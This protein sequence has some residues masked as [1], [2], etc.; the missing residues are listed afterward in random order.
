MSFMFPSP[1]M[2]FEAAVRD[3]AQGKVKARALAAQALGD[4]TDPTEKRRAVQA[5][6]V[7]LDD[8]EPEVRMEA[9]SSLGELRDPSAITLLVKRLDDGAPAVRQHAAIALGSIGGGDAC[10]PLAQALKSGPP[11]LRFQAAT[12]IAEIDGAR[13]FEPLVAALA[14]KDPQVVAAAA[15]SLGAIEDKTAIDPLAKALDHKEAATRFDIAY[16]LAEL[17]DARGREYLV[18]GLSQEDRAWDAVT[19]I[20]WLGGA[21]D[22]EA[23]GR[24]VASRHTPTEAATLAA[25]KLLVIQPNGAHHDAARKFLVANLTSRKGHVRGL[26]I[27][28]LGAVAG[29]WAIAPLEKLAKSYKGSDFIDAIGAALQSIKG[30]A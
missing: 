6:L 11:D 1:S 8:N 26:A 19:A 10:E 24:A 9:A 18:A 16:A 28:Q 23:L 15:L 13:A 12:S 5:L 14:D 4:A 2:K 22:A 30:R 20:A 17:G 7:A 21:D 27:E 25:G 3:V 29:S